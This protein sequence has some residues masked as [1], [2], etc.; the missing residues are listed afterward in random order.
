[1]DNR[2][3][4]YNQVLEWLGLESRAELSG[5]R[6]IFR[7]TDGAQIAKQDV[8]EILRKKF[9]IVIDSIEQEEFYAEKHDSY[10][11][12]AKVA[13]LKVPNVD[14]GECLG[15]IKAEKLVVVRITAVDMICLFTMR[16]VEVET[17][18]KIDASNVSE[19]NTSKIKKDNSRSS[20]ISDR[21]RKFWIAGKRTISEEDFALAKGN[22]DVDTQEPIGNF[23][24]NPRTFFS[25]YKIGIAN[26]SLDFNGSPI[27][28]SIALFEHINKLWRQEKKK[29][30]VDDL[31][32]FDVHEQFG[33][34]LIHNV[35]IEVYEQNVFFKL[36]DKQRSPRG[37]WLDEY[38]NYKNVLTEIQKV[39]ISKST[40]KNSNEVELTKNIADQMSESFL[41]VKIGTG[42]NGGIDILMGDS[43]FGIEIKL[44]E[45]L[46]ASG[47]QRTKGQIAEYAKQLKSPEKLML[48]VIGDSK[49]RQTANVR[50]L[51]T[52]IEDLGSH[53]Y[54]H[55]VK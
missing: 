24:L 32:L 54:Y 9:G 30:P 48:M 26:T 42:K 13:F 52:E 34:V 7:N 55:E 36:I 6:L 8:V 27:E 41:S 49:S 46:T 53:F 37:R 51:E 44:V 16:S 1:M 29:F 39:S 2:A 47:R 23:I 38:V 50:E 14:S 28:N 18:A 45:A 17:T 5:N 33:A 4:K 10:P 3:K 21:L 12:G 43:A 40:F 35:K 15:A 31:Y 25:G 19:S 20:V 22:I 11:K